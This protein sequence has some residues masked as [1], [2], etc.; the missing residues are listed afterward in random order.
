MM[1][2]SGRVLFIVVVALLGTLAVVIASSQASLMRQTIHHPVLFL[3][4]GTVAGGIIGALDILVAS[5]LW[6]LRGEPDGHFRGGW[7]GVII[8]CISYAAGGAGAGVGFGG[9]LLFIESRFH[10][11]VRFGRLASVMLLLSV[12][13][14]GFAYFGVFHWG[15]AH[16]FLICEGIVF[17]AC[18]AAALLLSARGKDHQPPP[19]PEIPADGGVQ[20]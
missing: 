1:A 5:M 16:P 4:F 14:F 11:A 6:H 2:E 17:A 18:S 10:R 7:G 3:V 15:W 12:S 19:L 13:V 9:V 20:K 8:G